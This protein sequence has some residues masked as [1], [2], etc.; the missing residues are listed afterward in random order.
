MSSTYIG[1][2]LSAAALPLA[3]LAVAMVFAIAPVTVAKAQD[4]SGSAEGEQEPQA[5][6]RPANPPIEKGVAFVNLARIFSTSKFIEAKRTEI[7]AEFAD[8]EKEL[9]E[10]IVKLN[11]MRE[12]QSRDRL[13]QTAEQRRAANDSLNELDIEIQRE[14]RN[15]NEDRRLR[16]DGVQR[17]LEEFVLEQIQQVSFERENMIVFDLTTILFADARLEITDE[18]ITRLDAL[19]P[20]V[21]PTSQ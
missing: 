6:D 19:D 5:I 11:E 9:E 8:R 7:N 21:L 17:D 16:F 20:D 10:K 18:V 14:Q 15:L 2:R 3:L 12:Q 1:T 4:E 13:T